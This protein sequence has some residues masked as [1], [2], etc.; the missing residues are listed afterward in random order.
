MGENDQTVKL[1]TQG[2]SDLSAGAAAFI[3]VD[4]AGKEI[5]VYV[6]D[7]YA[8]K[9]PPLVGVGWSMRWPIPPLGND[10]ANVLMSS[11]APH[12]RNL[13]SSAVVSVEPLGVMLN[14]GAGTSIDEIQR[15]CAAAWREFYEAA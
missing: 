12:A 13:F 2:G 3:A 8:E 5:Y 15:K 1:L 10:A 14:S 9:V 7:E 4:L 11:I 6:A